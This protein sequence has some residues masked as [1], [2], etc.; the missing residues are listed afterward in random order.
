MGIIEKILRRLR[1]RLELMN[2][3]GENVNLP[4][5]AQITGSKILGNV[6]IGDRAKIYKSDLSGN[7]RIGSNTSIWGPNTD[8]YANIYE[9]NIGKFCSVARNVSMQE[10]NH[11]YEGVTTYHVH[12]NVFHDE[13]LHDIYSNGPIKIGNDVWIGAHCVILSGAIIGDGA[14]IAANSVVTGTIPPYAIAGGSPAKVLKFRFSEEISEALLKIEWWNW[15]IEKI[16]GHKEL[17][18]K[19]Q[20][21]L[22]DLQPFLS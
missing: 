14:I 10:Y 15:P 21:T 8:L 3:I 5:S 12:R 18:C 9:I 20:I 2:V 13:P 7:I 1:K 17:F 22:D 4:Q 11:K 16:E 6:H 19:D